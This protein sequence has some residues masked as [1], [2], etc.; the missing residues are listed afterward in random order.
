MK[1]KGPLIKVCGITNG[2][3]AAMCIEHGVDLMGFIFHPG[4]PR[5]VETAFPASIKT[6]RLLKVGV[7]VKQTADEINEIMEKSGLD[8]AQ[9]HGGQ[10]PEFCREVGTKRVIKAIWPDG[11]ESK[12]EFQADLDRFAPVCRFLLFDSGKS[13]GGHGTSIDFTK[14]QD[15]EIKNVWF[16]AGG[17][18]PENVEQVLGL[19]PNGLDLN[20]GVE[21]SPGL[22]DETKLKQVLAKVRA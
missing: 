3:D 15:V 20:S 13:G 1:S 12:D 14:L 8:L 10:D 22:K 6:D 5:N 19:N 17:I 11:Y 4:S 18:S 2:P 16:V 21:T 7:F 9:L